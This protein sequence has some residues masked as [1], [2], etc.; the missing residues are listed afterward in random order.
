ML[1]KNYE[2]DDGFQTVNFTRATAF[3]HSEFFGSWNIRPSFGVRE[4]EIFN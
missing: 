1:L 3:N 4:E 2:E